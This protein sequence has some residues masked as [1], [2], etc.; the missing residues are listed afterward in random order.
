MYLQVGE[1]LEMFNKLISMLDDLINYINTNKLITCNYIRYLQGVSNCSH[2]T[3]EELICSD[4][5]KYHVFK[6][7]LY[8][9]NNL[10]DLQSEMYTSLPSFEPD[11]HY[12]YV[13]HHL[14]F[15]QTAAKNSKLLKR[16]NTYF[17]NKHYCDDEAKDFNY[18]KKP[19]YSDDDYCGLFDGVECFG[20]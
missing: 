12:F 19:E 4:S 6:D 2:E 14:R 17:N 1:V 10:A 20:Y 15:I 8:D 16:L 9:V 3:A 11:N 18:V 13:Y 5:T 7:V